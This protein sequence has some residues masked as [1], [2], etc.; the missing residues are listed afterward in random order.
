MLS[1]GVARFACLLP[2]ERWKIGTERRKTAAA[3]KH[4]N[5]KNPAACHH[6][7]THGPE[8]LHKSI[9]RQ[10]NGFMVPVKVKAPCCGRQHQHAA[11]DSTHLPFPSNMLGLFF[12]ATVLSTRTHSLLFFFFN[13]NHTQRQIDSPD[14]L[15]L[16]RL[17]SAGRYKLSLSMAKVRETKGQCRWV[18][19]CF[20]QSEGIPIS[21][22]EQCGKV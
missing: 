14:H 20:T 17:C 4:K 6:T 3:M 16:E 15:L 22:S 8:R 21:R 18:G 19:Y 11:D 2:L 1:C 10:P 13:F 5:T 7:H 9:N 12:F